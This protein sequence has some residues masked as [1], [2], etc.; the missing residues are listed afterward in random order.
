MMSLSGEVKAQ[1]A[2]NHIIL[3]MISF[4][5]HIKPPRIKKNK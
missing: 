3:E 2:I 5:L 4:S 1:E